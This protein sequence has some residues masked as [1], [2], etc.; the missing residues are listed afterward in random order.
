MVQKQV[1][2]TAFRT[3]LADSPWEWQPVTVFVIKQLRQVIAVCERALC[4]SSVFSAELKPVLPS[5]SF[6]VVP[7]ISFPQGQFFLS[8]SLSPQSQFHC[9]GNLHFSGQ[10]PCLII[11]LYY[12]NTWTHQWKERALTCWVPPDPPQRLSVFGGE[13]SGVG[14]LK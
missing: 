7:P 8:L 3:V 1:G 12:I 6:F 13:G 10:F 11:T 2:M 5:S 14:M 4:L 9:C